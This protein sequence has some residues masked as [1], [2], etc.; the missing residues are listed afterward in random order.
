MEL[1]IDTLPSYK[2]EV[3]FEDE[4][5]AMHVYEFFRWGRLLWW[6]E[7]TKLRKISFNRNSITIHTLVIVGV[8]IQMFGILDIL[9]STCDFV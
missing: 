9:F 6:L 4:D 1:L 2:A 5:N 7:Y 3:Y 8:M